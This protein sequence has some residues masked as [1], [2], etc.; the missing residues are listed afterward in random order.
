MKKII[1]VLI[2]VLFTII[3]FTQSA[4]TRSRIVEAT[5]HSYI[6]TDTAIAPQRLG[7]R[8]IV[9]SE[10]ISREY[11]AI[12]LVGNHKWELIPDKAYVDGLVI[13]DTVVLYYDLPNGYIL[14]NPTLDTVDI[15]LAQYV[16]DYAGIIRSLAF[17]NLS[18]LFTVDYDDETDVKNPTVSFNLSNAAQNAVLAGPTSGTGTPTYRAL[19]AGDIPNLDASKITT[20]TVAAARLGSGTAN[21]TTVLHGDNVYRTV[22]P[23]SIGAVWE[24]VEDFYQGYL[25][26]NFTLYNGNGGSAGAVDISDVSQRGIS[27]LTS[28]TSSAS[29]Y[30]LLVSHDNSFGFGSTTYSIDVKDITIGT[31]NSA[32]D[33]SAYMI[34]WFDALFTNG[35]PADGAYIAYVQTEAN[36][37]CVTISNGTQTV[38]SSTV[39]VG[40]GYANSIDIEI[41]ANSTSVEFYINGAIQATHTTNIPTGTARTFSMGYG[42][43]KKLGTGQRTFDI[44]RILFKTL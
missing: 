27:R 33:S 24:I 11:R 38:T 36:W 42:I 20:G 17:G 43:R 12:A 25:S 34:G 30:A 15:L 5:E 9:Y 10:G 44:D 4:V 3:G 40:T 28:G 31:L 7:E 41:R 22:T 6:P 23:T 14:Y 18:P 35:N 32:S 1:L 26:G 13:A 39:P 21:S 29:A 19:V 16:N 8:R 37:R 2:Y